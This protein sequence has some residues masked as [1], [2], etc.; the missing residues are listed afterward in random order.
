VI[1]WVGEIGAEV[2]HFGLDDAFCHGVSALSYGR[3]IYSLWREALGSLQENH[4]GRLVC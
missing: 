2:R 4:D 3:C 1:V